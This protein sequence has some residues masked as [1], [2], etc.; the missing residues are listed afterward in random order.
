MMRLV[1]RFNQSTSRSSP[2]LKL[3]T[4]LS[5]KILSELRN[6]TFAAAWGQPRPV[7]P[8][9]GPFLGPFN[10]LTIEVNLSALSV[11][12]V[13]SGSR[14]LYLRVRSRYAQS[15]QSMHKRLGHQKALSQ[16][17]GNDDGMIITIRCSTWAAW[18]G[19]LRGCTSIIVSWHQPPRNSLAHV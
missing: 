12:M 1:M 8:S 9:G 5:P 16:K 11:T 17:Y 19:A 6:H 13:M 3:G 10:Q 2:Q 4:E 7:K 14:L 18:L 15:I